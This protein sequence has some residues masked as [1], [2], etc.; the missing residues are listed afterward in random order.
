LLRVHDIAIVQTSI[1]DFIKTCI[2]AICVVVLPKMKVILTALMRA[3][4]MMVENRMRAA[5]KAGV[6]SRW[7]KY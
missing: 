1:V 5:L 4:P 3:A 7:C 6:E 2:F